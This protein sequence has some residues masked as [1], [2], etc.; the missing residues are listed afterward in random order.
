MAD[1]PM[2]KV[3]FAVPLING[4]KIAIPEFLS[5]F[6][7]T[8]NVDIIE[9]KADGNCFFDA[10]RLYGQKYYYATLNKANLKL[11]ETLVD[12]ILARTRDEAEKAEIKKLRKSGVYAC[13]VGD[14]PPQYAH[15]VFVINMNLF[16]LYE[17]AKGVYMNQYQF[18][19]PLSRKTINLL[20]TGNHY[21]VIGV[22]NQVT[23]DN[24]IKE[25][26]AANKSTLPPIKPDPLLIKND[27]P[28]VLPKVSPKALEDEFDEKEQE[29][30]VEE[31]VLPP[32]P[33]PSKEKSPVKNKSDRLKT[34]YAK[35]KELD[36]RLADLQQQLLVVRQRKTNRRTL[37][38]KNKNINKINNQ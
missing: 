30:K 31:K 18:K 37:K 17:D 35:K 25:W 29:V 32:L 34:L 1:E 23:F 15:E 3:I 27:L 21:R 20:R 38:N 24:A 5:M 36:D 28:K 4:Q 33:L 6:K 12:Y 8:Y 10:L 19:N 9:T 22:S 13:N 26:I 16:D 14:L 2:V 11:R 7:D